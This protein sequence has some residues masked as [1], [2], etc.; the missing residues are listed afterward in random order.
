MHSILGIIINGSLLTEKTCVIHVIP[1]R[2]YWK[3]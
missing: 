3:N 2:S 1:P